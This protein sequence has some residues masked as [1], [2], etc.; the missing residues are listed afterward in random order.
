MQQV[1]GCVE[2]LG[3]QAETEGTVFLKFS[4]RPM[5]IGIV[6]LNPSN[7]VWRNEAVFQGGRDKL[8]GWD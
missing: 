1:E 6:S 4:R 8:G 2:S 3:L 5:N 7:V